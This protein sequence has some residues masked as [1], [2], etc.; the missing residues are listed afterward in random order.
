[1]INIAIF[2]S[3]NGSNAENIIRYFLKSKRIRVALILSNRED[4]YV[5]KRGRALGVHSRSF[6]KAE[7]DEGKSVLDALQAYSVDFIVL[8]GFL[9]KVSQPILEA[10]PDRILNIHPALLPKHGGKGMY[11]DRVHRAVIDAGDTES[12]ITIHYV[13]EHYDEGTILFQARCEVLS[14]DSAD[15]VARKV[16]ELEYLHFPKVIEEAVLK[17]FPL[18]NR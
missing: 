2:A 16:H 15:D 14:T 13:N 17:V 11:G 5:H 1:M 7:F 10:Y 12:G 18:P 9:L 3:G 6:R 4:A 8:A